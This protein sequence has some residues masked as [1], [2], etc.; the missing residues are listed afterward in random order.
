MSRVVIAGLG[1]VNPLSNNKDEFF[2]SLMQ[3]KDGIDTIHTI[4]MTNYPYTMGGEVKNLDVSH[5]LSQRGL[6]RSDRATQLLLAATEEAVV[7][8]DLMNLKSEE[9]HR[10]SLITG[11]TLGGMRS[12][13]AFYRQFVSNPAKARPGCLLDANQHAANDHV[14]ST[15]DFHGCSLVISTACSASGHAIGYGFDVIRSEQADIVIAGGFDVMSELTFSGFS[16][17][18]AMTRDKIRPFDRGRS[19]LVLG[20][21]AGVIVLEE[22]DHAKRRGAR[23]YAEIVG[24]GSSSDAYHMTAPH[25]TGEGAAQAI[26]LALQDACISQEG[27]DYINAHGTATRANDAAET[28]AIKASLGQHAYG[29]PVSSIKSMIGHLLGAAGAVEAIATI[30]SIYH[31]AI[32]PTINYQ[33]PDPKCD[34]DYVPNE[35]RKMKVNVALSNSFGFGGNNCVLV[36]KKFHG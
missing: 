20:E 15:F 30:M 22:M 12:G 2:S 9:R 1:T 4:D 7:D 36:F 24:Y 5:L 17:L 25:P 3:G 28:L 33:D 8:A 19:G 10:I 35:G 18:R 31:D 26:T 6:L 32:P 27:V 29:I 14:M 16:I 13:E 21:G 11:T 23:V 34:L